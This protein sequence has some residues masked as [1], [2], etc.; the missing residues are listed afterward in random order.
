MGGGMWVWTVIS[1]FVV[2]LLIVAITRLSKR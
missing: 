2:L 1:V